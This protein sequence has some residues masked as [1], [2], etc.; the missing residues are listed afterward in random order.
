MHFIEYNELSS[1]ETFS[2]LFLDYVGNFDAVAPFFNGN[3]R[4]DDDWRAVLQR[5]SARTLDRS[6]LVQILQD[7]N[8]NFQCG[9]R[10]LANID[11]LINDNCVAVVTGQQVGLFT[12][13]LYTIYK[14]L[15]AIKLA[16]SL[17]SRFPEY[18]FVPVFWLEGEDHDVEEIT[19]VSF[20]SASNEFASLRYAVP[21]FVPGKNMGSVGS[22]ELSESVDALFAELERQLLPT[23]FTPKVLE[24]LRAAYQRG[25]TFNRAFVHLFNVLVEDSG[26]IFFDPADTRSKKMLA[27]VF[28]HELTAGSR[29]C[30]LVIDQ[31]EALEKRFHAQVKPRPINLFLLHAGGRHPIEPHS[32]GFTLKGVR[33]HFRQDDLLQLLQTFP[34]QFSPNVVLRPICQDALFPTVSYVAG[35]AEVAY[36][37]QFGPVYREFDLVMPIIYPRASMTILEE[38]IEKTIHRFQL[39][40]A[41]LFRDVE[42]LK[43]QVAVHISD[44]DLNAV[45]ATSQE[46]LERVLSQLRPTLQA[47][48]QTLLGP[49]DTTVGK[50]VQ[51]LNVLKEKAI[52]AQ[53]RQHEAALRQV[54]RAAGALFPGGALQERSL[55]IVYFL[56][57]YGLEFIRWIDG[58]LVID[59]FKHQ[60]VTL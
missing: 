24:L 13:P 60:V 1:G 31:S 30:Q 38:R 39:R 26:L 18:E 4:S 29:T 21:G 14:A 2:R 43:Q 55:N 6:S 15:T 46:D 36:F 50:S 17:A 32:D 57:K 45:F 27:P 28:H 49:L 44:L 8:R 35:P 5:V 59:R 10:T 7:Q 16:H 47:L 22:M 51:N 42:L 37:A 40:F 33:Q 52:A 56:N 48:D 23:E 11:K 34:E 19:G 54:E 20:F 12:G 58:E 3:Y 9:V 53:K 25:M 41:D